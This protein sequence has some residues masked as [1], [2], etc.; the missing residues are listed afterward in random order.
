MRD[1]LVDR[2][3]L[4]IGLVHTSL[5]AIDVVPEQPVRPLDGTDDFE[6]IG[7]VVVCLLDVDRAREVRHK[8]QECLS[9]LLPLAVLNVLG[10]H[11]ECGPLFEIG[12]VEV[13]RLRCLGSTQGHPGELT[14]PHPNL[15]EVTLFLPRVD[16]QA[17]GKGSLVLAW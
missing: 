11:L 7:S 4:I 14:G 16:D 10:G 2:P 17:R 6:V 8:G 13:L 9:R 15:G 3:C 12:E 1:S 5:N